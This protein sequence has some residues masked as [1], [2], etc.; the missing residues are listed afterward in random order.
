VILMDVRMPQLNGFEAAAAIRAKSLNRSTPILFLSAFD[1]PP[2]H[3]FSSY[4]GG[5]ADFLSSPVDAETLLRKVRNFVK[6]PSRDVGK[7]APSD[8]NLLKTPA[9][10]SS[11]TPLP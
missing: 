9:D 2:L 4:V 1:S 5:K 10:G 11:G 7:D 6:T 8:P 3:V